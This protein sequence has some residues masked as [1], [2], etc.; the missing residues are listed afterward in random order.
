MSLI[1]ICGFQ[2]S[3]KDTLANI[4][5]EKG[6]TKVSFAG[7]LKDIVSII[8][9]WDRDLLEGNTEKSRKWREEVDEWWSNR[10]N[11]S[12]LTPRYI[13]QH[14]GTDI[15]RNHFHQDIW[16]AAIERKISNLSGVVITDCRFPN[17]I[18]LIKKLNGS[19]IH[20]H[21]GEI[22]SWFGN[23][24]AFPKNIHISELLW[25]KYKFDKT[26]SNDGDIKQLRIKM[27]GYLNGV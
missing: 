4:L 27:V 15:F 19:L 10:L 8:F 16:V 9:S 20:I 14:I 6:Y 22:P 26:I 17:E 24:K 18:E 1:A 2:G 12:N 3:G 25:T 5:I 11:I 23:E 7:L 13:L 21:R